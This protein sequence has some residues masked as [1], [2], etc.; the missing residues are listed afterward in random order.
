MEQPLVSSVF[1]FY[2]LPDF[3]SDLPVKAPVVVKALTKGLD[4]STGITR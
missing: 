3:K 4:S 1:N 2:L